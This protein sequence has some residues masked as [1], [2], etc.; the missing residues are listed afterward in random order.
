MT[1]HK[2]IAK[3]KKKLTIQI[4]G[5]FTI[6]VT[7]FIGIQDIST[8]LHQGK[9]NEKQKASQCQKVGKGMGVIWKKSIPA[10]FK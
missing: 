9:E 7:V 4:M 2:I 3:E 8:D 1:L 6:G 5:E 10:R